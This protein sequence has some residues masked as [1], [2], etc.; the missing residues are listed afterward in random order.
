[1]N[2]DTN[3]ILANALEKLA[4]VLERIEQK[5]DAALPETGDK[6]D[7]ARILQISPRTLERRLPEL[8]KDV[9]YWEEGGKLVFDLELIRDWQRN[10]NNPAAHQRAIEAKRAK[11]LSSKR[12]RG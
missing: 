9:H 10:R 11:L 3:L 5:L 2:I 12:K 1:M 8:V 6:R 4:I 7:A